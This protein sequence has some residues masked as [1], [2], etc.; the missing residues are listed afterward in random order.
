MNITL[1]S[2]SH[3]LHEDGATGATTVLVVPL[4]SKTK[5]FS[6]LSTPNNTNVKERYGDVD[7]TPALW[8][9]DG[10]YVDVYGN[11]PLVLRETRSAVIAYLPQDFAPEGCGSFYYVINDRWIAHG[12]HTVTDDGKGQWGVSL[13]DSESEGVIDTVVSSI[14][15]RILDGRDELISVAVH[16]N[17]ALRLQLEDILQSFGVEVKKF[18]SLSPS[19]KEKP[20]YHHRD[21][22]LM[23]MTSA[24]I[25]FI[26][27]IASVVMWVLGIVELEKETNN[28]RRIQDNIREMQKN[29]TLGHVEDPYA[30]LRIMESKIPQLPSSLVHAGGDITRL[31]GELDYVS[32][33][34][35]SAFFNV[36]ERMNQN[37]YKVL[38]SAKDLHQSLLVDQER[39]ATSAL[40]ARPWLRSIQRQIDADDTVRLEMEIQVK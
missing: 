28:V 38:S 8:R 33:G 37:T 31:F 40:K 35:V 29:K 3:I 19:K 4:L 34:E 20:L 10:P 17:E 25:V 22:S 12:V 15:E 2:G 1:L 16:N 26:L 9:V 13:L 5:R 39:V 30:I 36:K 18:D 7:D 23:M 27:M 14:S 6:D 24:L 11:I 21:F 32:I